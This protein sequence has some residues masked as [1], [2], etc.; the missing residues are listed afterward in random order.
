MKTIQLFLL[1]CILVSCKKEN[2]YYYTNNKEIKD[3]TVIR[4][5]DTELKKLDIDPKKGNLKIYTT[6]DSVSYKTNLDTIRTKVFELA[7]KDHSIPKNRSL[8]DEWIKEKI[9][10]VDNKTAKVVKF[11][12]TF[13][14]VKLDRD[15]INM[16]GMKKLIKLGS[17]LNTNPEAEIPEDYLNTYASA[18]VPSDSSK[19]KEN[20]VDF[21]S[22]FKIDHPDRKHYNLNFLS[23]QDAIKIFQTYNRNGV[24]K[25]PFS[26]KSVSEN[27]KPLY[28][29]RKD[30]I[31]ILSSISTHTIQDRLDYYKDHHY[32]ISESQIKA[33]QNLYSIGGP[34]FHSIL[35]N[36]GKYTYF[37]YV[38]G[39]VITDHDKKQSKMI[40]AGLMKKIGIHY[41][42]AIRK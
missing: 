29:H 3:S 6:L 39:I 18:V 13:K 7:S 9:I 10:V 41:Y 28:T 24:Y 30:S 33:I 21:L 16:I 19:I 31:N 12:S 14:N 26:I 17:I 27:D 4:F 1:I 32:R 40:P 22:K 15:E 38:T 23:F 35:V 5:V 2:I 37:I 25:E 20:A 11:Y 42:N 34:T 8:F 36:D